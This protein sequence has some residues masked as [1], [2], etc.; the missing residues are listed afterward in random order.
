MVIIFHF[1]NITFFIFL[2]FYHYF[3]LFFV[4]LFG[5]IDFGEYKRFIW[6]GDFLMIVSFPFFLISTCSFINSMIK[7]K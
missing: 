1:Y 7:F 3:L 2:I 5:Q 6:E 4:L